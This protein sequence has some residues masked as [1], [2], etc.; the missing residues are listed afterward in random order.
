[1]FKRLF[2]ISSVSLFLCTSL[3]AMRK[4]E[5]AA[6]K[7]GVVLGATVPAVVVGT[8]LVAKKWPILVPTIITVGSPLVVGAPVVLAMA[9]SDVPGLS[10]KCPE[11]FGAGFM[12]G[13]SP[14]IIAGI[15]YAIKGL[16]GLRGN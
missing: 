6:L 9:F 15:I 10:G 7:A 11:Y 14:W 1:M 12:V 8:C 3:F 5:A 13:L 16:K 4:G 2:I